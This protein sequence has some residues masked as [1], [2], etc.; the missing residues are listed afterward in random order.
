MKRAFFIL[1]TTA[2]IAGV[3]AGCA[4]RPTPIPDAE[5][6]EA[7][8]Y[9]EKCSTCHSLAHPKRQ[10][11]GDWVQLMELMEEHM[12]GPLPDDERAAILE[13]LKGN[14]R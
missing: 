13:Y 7:R 9:A 2:A 4:G 12:G 8:L 3:L 11:E 6:P 1:F 5:T 14:S 10:A